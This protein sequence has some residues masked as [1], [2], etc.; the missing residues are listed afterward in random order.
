MSEN[1]L[2]Y[3]AM[4]PLTTLLPSTALFLYC[5]GELGQFSIDKENKTITLNTPFLYNEIEIQEWQNI[6]SQAIIDYKANLNS[7][8]EMGNND[9]L[10]FMNVQ[11]MIDKI[12]ALIE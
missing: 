9:D 12:K 8:E 3:P 1:Q 2:Q 10:L 4:L 7:G 11:E 5:A 6:L